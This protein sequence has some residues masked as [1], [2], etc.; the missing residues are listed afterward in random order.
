MLSTE[1][2]TWLVRLAAIYLVMGA[3][4]AIPF[5]ARWSGRIDPVARDGTAGFRLLIIPGAILLWPLLTFRLLRSR[6][7]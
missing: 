6:R 5:A 1:L 2:A 7:P 4:F 3:G